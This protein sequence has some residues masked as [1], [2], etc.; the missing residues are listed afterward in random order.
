[1]LHTDSIQRGGGQIP[2]TRKAFYASQLSAE[3]RLVEP[4][5]KVEIQTTE[6]TLGSANNVVNRRRGLILN[7]QRSVGSMYT[8]TC[9]LP[10]LESFGLTD[11]LR[12]ATQGQAFCNV[13]GNE[14][15]GNQLLLTLSKYYIVLFFLLFLILN[16]L[17]EHHVVCLLFPVKLSNLSYLL[18]SFDKNL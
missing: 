4:I 11:D 5:Y 17:L 6:Q 7:I 14:H 15:I 16:L 8:V 13:Q 3:P 18:T 12:A 10:V 9:N 2:A 1:M